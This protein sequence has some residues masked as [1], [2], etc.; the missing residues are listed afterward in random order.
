MKESDNNL[1]SKNTEVNDAVMKGETERC[2]GGKK[3][4]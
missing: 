4:R 2:R 3:D 1:K